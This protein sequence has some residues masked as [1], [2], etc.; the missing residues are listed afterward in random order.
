MDCFEFAKEWKDCEKYL[1]VFVG[2]MIFSAQER[3][4]LLQDTALAAWRK[5]DSFDPQKA[6]F[7]TWVT[8]IARYE[9][10]NYMRD[11]KSAKVFYNEE[12]TEL[13]ATTCQEE[14]E[15]TNLLYEN[16]GECISQLTDDKVEILKMKY[17]KHMPI[18]KM[19]SELKLTEAAVKEKLYRIRKELKILILQKKGA[20]I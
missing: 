9:C 17:F 12:L 15:N 14:E 7:K 19:A 6:S 2:S 8:G 16:I 11:R 5:T 1:R 13:V 4:D 10:L 18:S 3:E 20:A